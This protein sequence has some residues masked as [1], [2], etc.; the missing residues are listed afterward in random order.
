M[1]FHVPDPY[2]LELTVPGEV[3]PSKGAIFRRSPLKAET[4][5]YS[6]LMKQPQLGDRALCGGSAAPSPLPT[7]DLRH[8]MSGLSPGRWPR[9]ALCTLPW[10]PEE[11]ASLRGTCFEMS[12]RVIHVVTSEGTVVSIS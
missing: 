6:S 12:S 11:T 9:D 5:L 1:H 10:A 3:S 8:I 2:V 4:S 7:R